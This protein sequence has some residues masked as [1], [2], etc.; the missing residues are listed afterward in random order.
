MTLKEKWLGKEVKIIGNYE[1]LNSYKL[2]VESI[3]EPGLPFPITVRIGGT[4]SFEWF[5]EDELNI[6]E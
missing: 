3:E 1:F 5:R 2:I 6:V 4:D